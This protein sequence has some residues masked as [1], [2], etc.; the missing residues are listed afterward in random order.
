LGSLKASYRADRSIG[1]EGEAQ[2]RR[3]S[4]YVTQRQG[5]CL[6]TL[7]CAAYQP[8]QQYNL[9]GTVFYGEVEFFFQATI[10]GDTRTLALVSN[11]SPPDLALLRK[12]YNTL[13]T[14]RHQGADDLHVVDVKNIHSVVAVV[15]FP[16][17]R[18][19][20]FIGEKLGL[21]VTALGGLE[22]EDALA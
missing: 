18:D 6:R 13:W 11:H 22:E 9:G 8:N 16:F 12:S 2:D 21:E 14:C 17:E 5:T 1:M 3:K 20:F 15:P 7:A 10:H 4:S 19:K